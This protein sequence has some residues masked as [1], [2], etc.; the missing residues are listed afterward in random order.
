MSGEKTFT[1][2]RKYGWDVSSYYVGW[3]EVELSDKQIEEVRANPELL[4]DD[5]WLD[6]LFPWYFGMDK[7]E[8]VSD[9]WSKGDVYQETLETEFDFNIEDITGEEEG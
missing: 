6:S 1:I 9:S 5:H 3:K 4:Q 8:L 7:E 2:R